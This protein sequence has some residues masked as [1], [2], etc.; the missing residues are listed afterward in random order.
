MAF[1]YFNLLQAKRGPRKKLRL[2][3]TE[4]LLKLEMAYRINFAGYY[5]VEIGLPLDLE[6]TYRKSLLDITLLNRIA[7]G[8][9]NCLLL[10]GCY[11]AEIDQ[12]YARTLNA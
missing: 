10:T 12:F 9:R 6:I 8:L 2:N 11:I 3:P 7:R 5:V 1:Y 4:K